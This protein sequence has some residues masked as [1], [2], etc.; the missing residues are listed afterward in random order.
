[1]YQNSHN[2][3]NHWFKVNLTIYQQSP[4][5][6]S[7]VLYTCTRTGMY[8]LL[9]YNR[10]QYTLNIS[11]QAISSQLIGY[12]GQNINQIN[13]YCHSIILRVYFGRLSNITSSCWQSFAGL[14]VVWFS[15]SVILCIAP[16]TI[17]Y[18][19]WHI[20]W[21]IITK[22]YFCF[23]IHTNRSPEIKL[24]VK[25]MLVNWTFVHQ[26][27]SFS[28]FWNT[29]KHEKKI[30]CDQSITHNYHRPSSKYS[31]L[32]SYLYWFPMDQLLFFK[33]YLMMQFLDLCLPLFPIEIQYST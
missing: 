18:Q 32:V 11:F 22:Y 26:T 23:H 15:K 21:S 10:L 14:H 7:T 2:K 25:R 13:I 28:K 31:Q 4:I 3:A 17:R 27:T 20:I 24:N 9:K 16:S 33:I 30:T 19:F 12:T 8:F 6:T 5:I 1:M 29:A